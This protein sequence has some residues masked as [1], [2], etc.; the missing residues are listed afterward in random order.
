MKKEKIM[1]DMEF[2]RKCCNYGLSWSDFII[3]DN[4]IILKTPRKDTYVL[5]DDKYNIVGIPQ[6]NLS[7]PNKK[8]EDEIIKYNNSH[9]NVD[10]DGENVFLPPFQSLSIKQLLELSKRITVHS[11]NNGHSCYIVVNGEYVEDQKDNIYVDL[12]LYIKFLGEQI[13]QYYTNL[14]QM[15]MM[16][17]DYYPDVYS[18]INSIMEIINKLV[19][20]HLSKNSIPFPSEIINRLG[21]TNLSLNHCNHELFGIVRLLLTMKKIEIK[22]YFDY[23]EESEPLR[24]EDSDL[25]ILSTKLLKILDVSDDEVRARIDDVKKTMKFN[26]INL[27]SFFANKS[28]D[29]N[30]QLIKK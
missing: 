5:L 9:N 13:K 27:K 1:N 19:E 23:Y 24:N 8:I 6:I 17:I 16:G 20:E 15:R 22:D 29:N 3:F 25:S 11:C 14:Y 28:K 12:L 21:Q 30:D 7:N 2:R 18:Y 4:T 26:D 10:K